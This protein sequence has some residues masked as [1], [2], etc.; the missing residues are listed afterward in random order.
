[1]V[2]FPT[3]ARDDAPLTLSADITQA[4]AAFNDAPR[5]LGS[6]NQIAYPGMHTASTAAVRNHINGGLVNPGRLTVAGTGAPAGG[7]KHSSPE[8]IFCLDRASLFPPVYCWM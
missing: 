7:P 6:H 1:M 3:T 8:Q 5:S 2:T 4:G